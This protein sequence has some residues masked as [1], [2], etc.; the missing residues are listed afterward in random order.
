MGFYSDI[1]LP[2]LCDLAMR[3]KQ[4][5]PAL[6]AVVLQLVKRVC[7]D[8]VTAVRLPRQSNNRRLSIPWREVIVLLRL[9]RQFKFSLRPSSLLQ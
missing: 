8:N 2:R 3:N 5:L 1:I 9:W 7:V 6:R 4:L